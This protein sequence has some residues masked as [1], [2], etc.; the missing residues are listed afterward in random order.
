MLRQNSFEPNDE[1]HVIFIHEDTRSTKIAT[2]AGSESS[3]QHPAGENLCEAADATSVIPPSAS[4]LGDVVATEPNI[5]EKASVD[6]G[7]NVPQPQ[8]RT[9]STK[10][11]ETAMRQFNDILRS[12]H[13]HTLQLSII[14]SDS[15]PI[16]NVSEMARALEL[17]ITNFAEER[18]SWKESRGRMQKLQDKVKVEYRKIYPLEDTILQTGTEV[19]G[20]F[21]D[22]LAPY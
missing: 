7:L 14:E 18:E 13:T 11:F 16:D 6:P 22:I 21:L 17:T 12:K 4:Q 19:T 2:V 3:P 5:L 1:S 20:I 9:E 10:V 15:D 8:R